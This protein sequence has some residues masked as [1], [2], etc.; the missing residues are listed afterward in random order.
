M[1]IK[2]VI[3]GTGFTTLTNEESPQG[4][5]GATGYE[6]DPIVRW[7]EPPYSVYRDEVLHVG[8][9]A[10]HSEGIKE[11]EFILN[12]G[13]GVKVTEQE[14]NPTTNLPEYCVRIDRSE[15]LGMTLEGLNNVEVRAIVRPVTGQVK[16]MQHDWMGIS[17]DGA[18]ACRSADMGYLVNQNLGISGGYGVAF[19]NTRLRPGKHSFV[20]SLLKD[21]YEDD[22]T[23]I[24]STLPD[25]SRYVSTSGSDDTGTGTEALP[26]RTMQKAMESIRDSVDSYTVLETVGGSSRHYKDISRGKVIFK[27]GEFHP[28]H[29]QVSD[30]GNGLAVSS[31]AVQ[32]L[33]TWLS[34]VGT[35]GSGGELLTSFTVPEGLSEPSFAVESTSSPV[36]VNVLT[37]NKKLGCLKIENIHFKRNNPK[38]IQHNV[39]ICAADCQQKPIPDAT[40][41]LQTPV[42]DGVWINNCIIEEEKLGG[43][44][45]TFAM[46]MNTAT[47]C[48]ISTNSKY[49]G[50]KE[51]L[52]SAGVAVNNTLSCNSGDQFKMTAF[53]AG[54][55]LSKVQDNP[56]PVRKIWFAPPEPDSGFEDYT[57][58]NGYY[59]AHRDV[60][61][62]RDQLSDSIHDGL[63]FDA[64]NGTG[65]IWT[66]IKEDIFNSETWGPSNEFEIDTEW[67]RDIKNPVDYTVRK[68]HE[69]GTEYNKETGKYF[70]DVNLDFD[71]MKSRIAPFSGVPLLSRA[72]SVMP[73]R[74]ARKM[75]YGKD[76]NN[77]YA[78]IG[79]EIF[80]LIHGDMNM[81]LVSIAPNSL[82]NITGATING[83]AL[84]DIT[85]P[86]VQGDDGDAITQ[87]YLFRNS[88]TTSSSGFNRRFGG[89]GNFSDAGDKSAHFVYDW[90]NNLSGHTVGGPYPL[91][92]G[93]ERNPTSEV[94]GSTTDATPI[95][96]HADFGEEDGS[97]ADVY[98]L[99]LN[100]TWPGGGEVRFENILAAYDECTNM[101]CQPWNMSAS[102]DLWPS[103]SWRD[104]A[105]I[106]CVLA[107]NN[108]NFGK[109]GAVWPWPTQNMLWFNNIMINAA[110]TF[111]FGNELYEKYDSGTTGSIG[112]SADN[113]HRGYGF[114]E[115]SY[116]REAY[117]HQPHGVS[118]DRM[119][120]NIVL[121]NNILGTIS[122]ELIELWKNGAGTNNGYTGSSNQLQ[123]VNNYFWPYSS[124]SSFNFENMRATGISAG[125]FKE[126]PLD[127]GLLF[128]NNPVD[129][130][131]RN[132]DINSPYN[133]TP[134]FKS[135]LVGGGT[136]DP[137]DVNKPLVPFD[138]YRTKRIERST[139]GPIEPDSLRDYYNSLL[140]F[141]SPVTP[142]ETN[143]KTLSLDSNNSDDRFGKLYRVVAIDT[144]T[145]QVISHSTN[146]LRFE[147]KYDD[148]SQ[149]DVSP[150][151]IYEFETRNGQNFRHLAE[152]TPA[153]EEGEDGGDV[154]STS[155]WLP[156]DFGLIRMQCINSRYTADDPGSSYPGA[157]VESLVRLFFETQDQA[158]AFH[159]Q[160]STVAPKQIEMTLENSDTGA[161]LIVGLS[162]DSTSAY[163]G[164]NQVATKE[165]RYFINLAG[166]S[167]GEGSPQ[168]STL[169]FL[170]TILP[171]TAN[172]VKITNPFE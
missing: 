32:S 97:H 59:V 83:Y 172:P 64:S 27:E 29:Y 81:A 124:E 108:Y 136:H 3:S 54:N 105:W 140:E 132:F 116:L 95:W 76:V 167:E 10:Y 9:M 4:T 45:R 80:P 159:T 2:S 112:I 71:A 161:E 151:D 106:N 113:V 57:K 126:L 86:L 154:L 170:G 82:D 93:N 102:S 118:F 55:K 20:G 110:W 68:Y 162:A 114:E 135:S 88:G 5:Q 90:S 21:N 37:G 25:I 104:I 96:C 36:H 16:I 49:F 66:K 13:T 143:T 38:K 127:P 171:A 163:F 61:Y 33:Q 120:K 99:F 101:D 121:K 50:G 133:Y 46:G 1:A 8:L 123:F 30:L 73:G 58:F 125:G 160:Y 168:G 15:L 75:F 137:S 150:F 139:V 65:V 141:D 79:S 56:L 115:G 92:H 6:F 70:P 128:E 22:N 94:T 43:G 117:A 44:Y 31:P 91:N 130:G 145:G 19:Q 7:T 74:A 153:T 98:Q 146:A 11:V 51:N 24:R 149:S 78:P 155:D 134:Y 89:T 40:G 156:K 122:G 77:P 144:D 119:T 169:P 111:R 148:F 47:K 41:I 53:T 72:H 48:W 18:T 107:G 100:N 69:V 35:V 129:H 67:F 14:I 17:A 63:D 147:N 158:N 152:Y 87:R 103:E 28:E 52:I 39:G 26:F 109:N 12:G 34:V 84:F 131:G 23:T 138:L 165:A 166:G 85:K 142:Y 62:L 42:I 164:G 157:K 60:D